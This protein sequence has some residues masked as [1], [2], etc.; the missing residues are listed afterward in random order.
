MIGKGILF[1]TKEMNSLTLENIFY[2]HDPPLAS[3]TIGETALYKVST[4][5]EMGTNSKNQSVY[6]KVLIQNTP[7]ELLKIRH[8]I[9]SGQECVICLEG[10]WSQ[11][12]AFLN[13]CGHGFHYSC[14]AKWSSITKSCPSCREIVCL[15]TAQ[16]CIHD[17]AGISRADQ[18]EMTPSLSFP[19][20]CFR[21]QKPNHYLGT[22]SQCSFCSQFR[23]DEPKSV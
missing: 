1:E 7:Q 19:Q 4:R 22:R 8:Y 13:S 14:I 21:R 11:R 9:S 20:L 12:N 10:I 3:M 6:K 16:K 2:A 18:I 23:K 15:D 17:N 5:W